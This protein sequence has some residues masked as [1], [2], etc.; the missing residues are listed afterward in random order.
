VYNDESSAYIDTQA[1]LKA[2][3]RLIVK[4]ENSKTASLMYAKLYLVYVREASIKE[5]PPC[6]VR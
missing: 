6:S 3:G 5:H 4:F 1:L 2:S